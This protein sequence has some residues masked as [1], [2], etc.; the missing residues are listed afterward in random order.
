MNKR[1]ISVI[2]MMI[3]LL[4][5]PIETSVAATRNSV[6]VPSQEEIREYIRSSGAYLNQK[7]TYSENPS[8]TS[9]YSA[10]KLS[11]D[12]YDNALGMVKNI[13]YIAGLST[14]IEWDDTYNERAQ[15]ASLVCAVN[16]ALSHTPAQPVGME[17]ALYNLGYSGASSSNIA[18]GYSTLNSAI[19]TGWM[20]DSDSSNRD[21]LGH[22]R[23]ILNPAMKKTGFG[24][25]GRYSAMHVIGGSVSTGNVTVMWP[26][27]QMPFEYFRRF[28]RCLYWI[29]IRNGV[30][31][32]LM[33]LI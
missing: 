25:V 3:G 27:Q 15:A 23:W 19:L 13:R 8:T 22:R 18:M 21:R 4:V 16:Q 17:D 26:A 29:Y 2:F 30:P 28:L 1:R 20:N 31:R 7:V 11:N 24:M 32:R 9:P 5:S 10:G 6:E 12:T 33:T 14:D